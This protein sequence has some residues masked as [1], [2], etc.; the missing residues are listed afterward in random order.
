M[1]DGVV[2]GQIS[3]VFDRAAS[4]FY[5]IALVPKP[6]R[7]AQYRRLLD[8]RDARRD[9][10]KPM[11]LATFMDLGSRAMSTSVTIAPNG[12]VVRAARYSMSS[13]V[14]RRMSQIDEN[15]AT[16]NALEQEMQRLQRE[17]SAPSSAS[18]SRSKRDLF[19]EL[20]QAK[21]VAR[22]V[23][24]QTHHLRSKIDNAVTAKQAEIT[25]NELR[26]SSVRFSAVAYALTAD[27]Y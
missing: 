16:S 10:R 6:P 4:T 20:S 5:L 19:A 24:N 2:R 8:L 17:L 15:V 14:Y 12:E 13:T 26:S 21:S 22:A 9:Q 1:L 7:N 25:N 11:P 23:R 18:S 3:V 27:D